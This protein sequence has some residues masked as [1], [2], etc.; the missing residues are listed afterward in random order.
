MKIIRTPN[1][2]RAV[3]E[4]DDADCWWLR[5]AMQM[6]HRI[7]SAKWLNG[8]HGNLVEALRDRHEGDCTCVPGRCLKCMAEEYLEISTRDELSHQEGA[9]IAGAFDGDPEPSLDEAI[10][11][12]SNYNPGLH[13][14]HGP[15]A[16]PQRRRD[17]GARTRRA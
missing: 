13:R 6:D 11:A 10:K 2:L 5:E 4:L 1:P 17:R 7:A 9:K 3:V 16:K 12:L 8:V 14:E 15:R